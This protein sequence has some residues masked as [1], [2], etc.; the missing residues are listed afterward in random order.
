MEALLPMAY[1]HLDVYKK[2]SQKIH[3]VLEKMMEQ[4]KVMDL[5]RHEAEENMKHMQLLRK[6][7]HDKLRMKTQCEH[8]N[9][10]RTKPPRKE[11]KEHDT[12]QAREAIQTFS[13]NKEAEQTTTPK[14]QFNPGQRI[15]WH[16]QH[17]I[18]G[19]GKFK[20]RWAGPY[21]IM[22]VYDNGS[23]DVTTL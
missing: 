16:L 2:R 23:V 3:P 18:H 5:T 22:Q 20:I 15:L 8:C 12:T 7:R 13:K 6:E 14:T 4:F 19:P 9:H 17:K 21:L 10:R 1:L 11:T